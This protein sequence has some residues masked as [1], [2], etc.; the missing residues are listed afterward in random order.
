M[1]ALSCSHVPTTPRRL[2]LTAACFAL[3]LVTCGALAA[4]R[5]P[6]AAAAASAAASS[7]AFVKHPQAVPILVYHHVQSYKAGYYLLYVGTSQFAGQL[8]Y[9]HHNGY[10]PVTLQ[11]VYDAWTGG[12]RLPRRPVVLSFDDGYLDQYT[13]AAHLLRRY[14]YP[15]VLN[16]VVHNGTPLSG[17]MVR[18]MIAWGWEVDSHT[19]THPLL[20]HL[21]S[22]QLRH[23]LVASKRILKRRFHVPV[24]FLC[25]PG[26]IYNSRVMRAVRAAGY[27]GATS[28]HYGRATPHGRF[29]M[30]RIAVYWGESLGAF[31]SR[32]RAAPRMTA[33]PGS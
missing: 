6:S 28:I 13:N 3:L 16:L 4:T 8:S 20:T 32:M 10:H 18:R 1:H 11:R 21:T 7:R 5:A 25:Y 19:L 27:L 24:D 12:A 29:A 17:A 30:P 33:A 2:W 26:G 23:Q 15:A 31:G 9:L 14:H 22:S